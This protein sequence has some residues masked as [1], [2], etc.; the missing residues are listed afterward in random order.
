[1]RDSDTTS[2]N[3]SLPEP[4]KRFVEDRVRKDGYTSASE[5]IRELLRT[6]RDQMTRRY[7]LEQ[8]VLDGLHSGP[9]EPED[10]TFW[11][12]RKDRLL[13]IVRTKRT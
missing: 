6:T 4:L 3:I 13:K 5:Y 9:A 1:M 8:L 7:E 2:L 11:Q 10:R 12:A